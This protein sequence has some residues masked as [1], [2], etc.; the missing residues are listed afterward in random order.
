MS[1]AR[2]YNRLLNNSNEEF[3]FHLRT[4]S[5]EN[6]QSEL[7]T[8]E[9]QLN[10]INQLNLMQ[11]KT[12]TVEIENKLFNKEVDELKRTVKYLSDSTEQNDVLEKMSL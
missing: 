1:C 11:G 7:N 12:T 8:I 9:T 2:Q 6:F 4:G 3:L 10:K 5:G